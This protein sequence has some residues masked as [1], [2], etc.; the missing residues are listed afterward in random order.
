M[1]TKR[2]KTKAKPKERVY[3][4]IVSQKQMLRWKINAALL[5]MAISLAQA[6]YYQE[7]TMMKLDGMIDTT[8]KVIAICSDIG[9]KDCAIVVKHLRK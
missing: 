3:A 5:G 9:V 1:A 6:W 8:S 4:K 2:R 7:I